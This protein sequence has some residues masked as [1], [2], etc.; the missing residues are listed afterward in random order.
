[1]RNISNITGPVDYGEESGETGNASAPFKSPGQEL[2]Q[3]ANAV[4]IVHLFKLY[5]IR[6]DR[7]NRRVTCPFK[8]HKNGQERTPSFWYF[9]ETNSFNCYGCHNGGGPTDFVKHMDGVEKVRA[10]AKILEL[11]EKDVDEDFIFEGQ[12]IS[13]R[14]EIMAEFSNA[15]L[16]FRQNYDDE[17]SFQFIEYVCWVYDRMNLVHTQDNDALRGLNVRLID[18]IREYKPYINLSF[19]DRYLKAICNLP[20]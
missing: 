4:P 5:K 7:F 16:E 3:R 20:V 6:I 1:M 14:S 2:V 9:P 15:V 11:F 12:N 17:H 18:W 8:F 10:A 13:E 19:E